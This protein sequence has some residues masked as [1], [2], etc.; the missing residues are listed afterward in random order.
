VT[1]GDP[2]FFAA[3]AK[4]PH[5][6]HP[7][8][9]LEGQPPQAFNWATTDALGTLSLAL[10]TRRTPAKVREESRKAIVD[11]AER[12]LAMSRADGFGQPYAGTRYPW[13]SNSFILNNGVV[14]AEAHAFTKDPRF[15]EGAAAAMDYV[16]G[17]NAL[18]KSYVSGYG[19][20]P[21][22]NP[23]HRAWAHAV[24]PRLPPPPPG[25]IAG[26]PNSDLQ[27][28]YS[29]ALHPGCIG[30][31]CYVDHADAYSANEVAINWNAALAWLSAYLDAT[32]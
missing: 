20:R 5:H 25:V 26:G 29:R 32:L 16:L 18:G 1:T 8:A 10:D 2:S 7:R 21:L 15:L 6:L 17:R 28:P 4:S 11:V 24:D 30:Q 12:Y 27:D 13:G 9:A 3:L 23:H 19:A 31:T 14:L 22:H